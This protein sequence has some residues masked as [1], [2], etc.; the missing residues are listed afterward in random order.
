MWGSQSKSVN[1]WMAVM[2]NSVECKNICW[3]DFLHVEQII[4]GYTF[5]VIGL[6]V[7]FIESWQL[8]ETLD[9]KKTW[10]K[11]RREADNGGG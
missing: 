7:T 5:I 11:S 2:Y 4:K 9:K 6:Q 1:E 3:Y 10:V 8:I